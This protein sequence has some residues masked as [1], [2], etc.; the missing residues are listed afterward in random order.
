MFVLQDEQAAP[1]GMID[2]IPARLTEGKEWYV[3]FYAPY[4]PTGQMRRKRIK[5]NRVKS[6]PLRRT[7]AREII[8]RI[9]GMLAG[10]WNPFVENAAPKC[11][12]RFDT[13]IKTYLEVQ[14]KELEVRSF[15]SYAS[16]VK[17]L[18]EY[19]KMTSAYAAT[20]TPQAQRDI[21]TKASDF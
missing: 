21:R 8:K 18:M 1:R 10:G 7:M 11:F 3:S 15:Q 19:L 6:V 12:H 17:I 13:A 2:Y 9:N 14:K 20:R 5:V 16:F 4:P